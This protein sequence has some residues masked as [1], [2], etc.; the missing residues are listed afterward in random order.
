MTNQYKQMI[1]VILERAQVCAETLIKA[2]GIG[3]SSETLPQ[4]VMR[5]L[6]S[7]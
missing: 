7:I 1:H 6:A 2:K 3:P 5:S 4:Q